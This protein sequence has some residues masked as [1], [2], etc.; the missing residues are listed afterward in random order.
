MQ[1]PKQATEGSSR[2]LSFFYRLSSLYSRSTT[3]APPASRSSILGPLIHFPF[4]SSLSNGFREVAR[5]EARGQ[6]VVDERASGREEQRTTH[7]CIQLQQRRRLAEN[8]PLR[9]CRAPLL[10]LVPP[11]KPVESV[12]RALPSP[13]SLNG[14]TRVYKL[15]AMSGGGK[16]TKGGKKKK[17]RT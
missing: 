11:G 5:G 6:T 7:A 14:H 16:I 8:R 9:W 15:P 2:R 3:A 13:D 4:V 1:Q 10:F 12:V 17:K